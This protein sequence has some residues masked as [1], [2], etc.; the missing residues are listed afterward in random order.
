MH[1][2]HVCWA[3]MILVGQNLEISQKQL[4]T[5]FC[6]SQFWK[7]APFFNPFDVWAH[8]EHANV[9][10]RLRKWKPPIPRKYISYFIS[11][12][13]TSITELN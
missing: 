5:S 4:E 9:T 7:R 3:A 12:E 13:F 6:S 2:Y 1:N 11:Y 8:S 10:F